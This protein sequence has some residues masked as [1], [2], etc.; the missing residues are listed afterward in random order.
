MC[1][2]WNHAPGCNCGFGQF[3]GGVARVVGYSEWPEDVQ[4]LPKLLERGLRDLGWSQAEISAFA[5]SAHQLREISGLGLAA[6]V[7]QLLHGYTF[8][9]LDTW[10][11]TLEIP[12]FYFG[13]PLIEGLAV[14]YS[15]AESVSPV[16]SLRA[17]VF[18]VGVAGSMTLEVERV[19]KYVA[20]PGQCKVVTLP[21]RMQVQRVRTRRGDHVVAEGVKAAVA[22][23]KAG[24]RQVMKRRGCRSLR[25]ATCRS[26]GQ[27]AVQDS[28][29]YDLTTD[30]SCE[31]T[32][33]RCNRSLRYG[34]EVSLA[35][36]GYVEVG[37]LVRWARRSDVALTFQ[38]PPGQ[39]YEASVFR[40]RLVWES[41]AE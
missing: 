32:E 20:G 18:G 27:G 31:P 19:A 36:K 2:A 40:D 17:K 29:S 8:D 23:P 14:T 5:S 28:V 21:I 6:R 13:A 25:A 7:R 9:V 38:L 37:P 22:V 16:A 33:V 24:P 30:L 34:R 15:E 35:L 4:R 1:N 26:T 10:T 3:D 12:L 11:E 41:P 39:L